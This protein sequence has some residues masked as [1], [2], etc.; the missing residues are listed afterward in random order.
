M[1]G[2]DQTKPCL[3]L[4]CHLIPVVI[5]SPYYRN[6][7]MD[8]SIRSVDGACLPVLRVAAVCFEALTTC[9]GA[10]TENVTKA[11]AWAKPVMLCRDLLN[12][13]ASLNFSLT[14]RCYDQAAN[15]LH[16]GQLETPA[17]SRHLPIALPTV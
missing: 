4:Q 9:A 11:A 10:P 13:M 12:V 3:M 14:R 15:P 8:Y 5:H 6:G 7:G 16:L 2:S 1:A 17:P